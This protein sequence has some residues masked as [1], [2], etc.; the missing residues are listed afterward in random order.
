MKVGCTLSSPLVTSTAARTHFGWWTALAVVVLTTSGIAER[1]G[2]PPHSQE[3]RDIDSL[4]M[5]AQSQIFAAIGEDQSGFHAV[6]G[7][8]GFRMDNAPHG[9]STEFRAEAVEFRHGSHQW[10]L[11][12]TGYGY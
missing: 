4:P 3:R 2:N 10:T 7:S 1:S 12:L 11:A 6:A 5:A 9:L 8:H